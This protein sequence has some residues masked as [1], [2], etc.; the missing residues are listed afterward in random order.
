MTAI[1]EIQRSIDNGSQ[2]HKALLSACR[3]CANT[4][5]FWMAEGET[6]DRANKR[7]NWQQF[8]PLAQAAVNEILEQESTNTAN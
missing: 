6:R 5:R 4:I 2:Y 3:S 7:A 1:E 8:G